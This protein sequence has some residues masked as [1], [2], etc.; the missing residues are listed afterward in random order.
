MSNPFQI[1]YPQD[2]GG[3]MEHGKEAVVVLCKCGE[4]HKTYG[5]RA[6][7]NG[8]NNWTFTWAFPIKELTSKREGY[9]Q[10]SVKGSISFA[11]D[12]PGC[13]YCGGKNCTVCSCGH[14]SCTI[15]KN[16]AFTCEWCGVQGTVEAYTGE[17]ISAGSDF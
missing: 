13:P 6:E 3:N 17:A 2:M 4:V 1:Q 15:L 14:L 7:K 16:K 8:Q 10:A 12:Y 11:D 5:I 9:D